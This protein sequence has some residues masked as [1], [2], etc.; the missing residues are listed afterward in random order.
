MLLVSLPVDIVYCMSPLLLLDLASRLLGPML[1]FLLGRKIGCLALTLSA[2]AF[3]LGV[4]PTLCSRRGSVSL[5]L[6]PAC[7]YILL[8]LLHLSSIGI[9]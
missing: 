7:S 9:Y 3:S 5:S 8:N 2:V 1:L 4:V 6:Q